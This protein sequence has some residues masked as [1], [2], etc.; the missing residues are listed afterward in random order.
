MG[1]RNSAKFGG[2]DSELGYGE[3]EED[4]GGGGDGERGTA[5]STTTGNC[6]YIEKLSCSSYTDLANYPSFTVTSY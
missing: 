3:V 4:V 2:I 6:Y 5:R 1:G